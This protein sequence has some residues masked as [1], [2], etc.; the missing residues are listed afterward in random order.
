MEQARVTLLS[1]SDFKNGLFH[2]GKRAQKWTR[3]PGNPDKQLRHENCRKKISYILGKEETT[4]CVAGK[5]TALG[6]KEIPIARLIQFLPKDH[7]PFEPDEIISCQECMKK[8]FGKLEA[9]TL[10]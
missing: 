7:L 6:K 2:A 9:V 3:C 8:L 4:L 1:H 5:I 10:T